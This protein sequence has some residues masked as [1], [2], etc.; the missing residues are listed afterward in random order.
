MKQLVVLL[1]IC[2]GALT[3]FAQSAKYNDAMTKAIAEMD[4][5]RNTGQFIAL[6]NKFERIAFAE[7]NQWLPYYY[8]ALSRVNSQYFTDDFS[9][10]DD[11]MDVAQR[12]IDVADSLMPNNSEIIL[13]KALVLRTRI[14]VH[15]MTRGASFG[16]QSSELIELAMQ[17][18][19]ENPRT[20]LEMGQ[21]LFYV[22]PQF[23]GGADQACPYIAKAK[24]KYAAFKPLS[25]LHPNWGETRMHELWMQCGFAA[26]P[27]QDD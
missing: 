22:P 16:R 23:G 7:K 3:T 18:D 1:V 10:T 8:A 15:P 9:L 20:Y 13:V 17:L 21:S 14:F 26:D 2:Q 6:S 11:I 24:E 5:L 19:P 4:T 27:G 12:Q 25:P